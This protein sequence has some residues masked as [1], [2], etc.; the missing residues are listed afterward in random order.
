[1]QTPAEPAPAGAGSAAA[2]AVQRADRRTCAAAGSAPRRQAA[3]DG[4]AFA[5]WLNAVRLDCSVPADGARLLEALA[6][7]GIAYR[8]ATRIWRDPALAGEPLL[9]AVG[10]L[11]GP[12]EIVRNGALA[13]VGVAHLWVRPGDEVVIGQPAYLRQRFAFFR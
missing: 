12:L 10:S 7:Q 8:L 9:V 6:A 13:S 4:A 11:D 3:Q 1:M 5:L 2:H